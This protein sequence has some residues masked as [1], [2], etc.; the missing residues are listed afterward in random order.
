MQRHSDPS[1]GVTL[2][3]REH[4]I[5]DLYLQIVTEHP[6]LTLREA[7]LAALSALPEPDPDFV[8]WLTES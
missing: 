6:D 8:A 5:T 4:E 2:S 7:A 3:P 1:G